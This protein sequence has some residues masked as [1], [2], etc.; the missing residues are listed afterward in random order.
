MIKT[1]RSCAALGVCQGDGRC[2]DCPPYRFAPGV[3][4]GP[5]HA[6]AQRLRQRVQSWLCQDA[7]VIIAMLLGGAAVGVLAK[8]CVVP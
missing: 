6:D 3:I 7:L 8:S 4:D 5:P 1:Y 2:A